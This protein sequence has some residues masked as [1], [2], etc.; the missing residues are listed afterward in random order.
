[1]T[2]DADAATAATRRMT[3]SMLKLGARA[4]P[5]LAT[6]KIAVENSSGVRRPKRS[7]SVP[8]V[9]CPM[10]R[11]KNH[12]ASVICALPKGSPYSASMAGKAGRYMSVESGPMAER[13]PSSKGSHQA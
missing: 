5:T 8:W 10:P 13:K 9:S 1:M 2:N 4:Q 11:P 3:I 12:A 7:D 6:V